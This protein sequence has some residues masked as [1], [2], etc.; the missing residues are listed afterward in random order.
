MNAGNLEKKRKAGSLE[1]CET[2]KKVRTSVKDF[3]C[4]EQTLSCLRT[5]LQIDNV[6]Q[7][8]FLDFVSGSKSAYVDFCK[9]V[10]LA[11]AM[12]V[13]EWGIHIVSPAW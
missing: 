11:G 3:N 9:D 10:I 1:E 12:K 7:Q 13:A 6:G 8:Q 4:Y 2:S 5:N